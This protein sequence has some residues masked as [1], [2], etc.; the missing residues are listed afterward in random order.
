MVSDV[1]KWLTKWSAAHLSFATQFTIH[2]NYVRSGK[3]TFLRHTR[4]M[5]IPERKTSVSLH[6]RRKGCHFSPVTWRDF[7]K[8]Q[9]LFEE[10]LEN[11]RPTWSRFPDPNIRMYDTAQA[12]ALHNT[13][14]AKINP[15][16]VGCQGIISCL[17]GANASLYADIT[18][19]STR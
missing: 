18:L 9:I 2:L 5:R 6:V 8:E 16:Q 4:I 12:A 10:F 13:H 19:G 1:V 17:P 15:K 7:C 11:K 3:H 14:R